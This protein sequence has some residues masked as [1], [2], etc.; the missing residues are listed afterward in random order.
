MSIMSALF[1]SNFLNPNCNVLN[2]VLNFN[3][4]CKNA[5]LNQNILIFMP[6]F[7]TATERDLQKKYQKHRFCATET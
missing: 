2:T 5:M 6:I 7:E 4:I 3:C 1:L